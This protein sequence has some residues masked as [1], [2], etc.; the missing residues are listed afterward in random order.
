MPRGKTYAN[1]ALAIGETPMIRINRLVP[2]GGA[3]SSPSVEFFQPLNLS[4]DRIGMA[5]IEARRALEWRINQQTHIY[6]SPRAEIPASR[7][8]GNVSAER[9]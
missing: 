8:A 7:V 4:K 3:T 6:P 9:L 1:A 2:E 5:M